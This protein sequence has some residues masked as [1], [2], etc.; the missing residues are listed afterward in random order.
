MGSNGKI[1]PIDHDRILS[2]YQQPIRRIAA[3][4]EHPLTETAKNYS[5]SIDINKDI[6]IL[7][8]HQIDEAEIANVVIRTTFLKLA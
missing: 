5:Q 2:Q 6:A 1:Y 7:R 8:E 4:G 3:Y